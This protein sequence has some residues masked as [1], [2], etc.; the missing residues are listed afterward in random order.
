MGKK[1]GIIGKNNDKGLGTLTRDFIKHLNIETRI[2]IEDKR[3]KKDIKGIYTHN[4]DHFI[5]DL[6]VDTL[7]IQEMPVYNIFQKCREKGI[8]TILCVN[9]EFLPEKMK[10]EPD[11]YQCS[12]SLNYN[13]VNSPNKVL[14]PYP[15]DLDGITPKIRSKCHVFVHNA[16][17]LGM[18]GANGTMELI[19]A[20][21]HTNKPFKMIIRSQVPIECN[22]PR[23]DLR[24]GSFPKEELFLEGDVF[25]LPQ[26]FRATSLPI[27][28]AMASGMPVLTS[29]IQPFN[30]FVNFT[31]EVNG[32]KN[33][34]LVR[35]IKVAQLDPKK[36]AKALDDLYDKNIE[37]ESKKAIEYGK[38][39]SWNNLKDKY[40]KLCYN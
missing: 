6:D 18:G 29:N 36:I 3:T 32:F 11:L 7:F 4:P 19:D 26:K 38:D 20:L 2:F 13:S 39:I 15:V 30:E 5:D 12:S 10:V 35:P 23:V 1:L 34:R 24:I 28:E 14:L 9:Y 8:K 17:T 37:E 40:L 21:K 27:Q 33:D 16:G 31:F 25:V 22:D